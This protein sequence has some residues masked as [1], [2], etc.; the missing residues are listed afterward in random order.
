[1]KN[2]KG[3]TLLEMVLSIIL[4][5]IIAGF[6]GGILFHETGM[7][8]LII[9]RKESKLDAKLVMERLLKEF[10][11]SYQNSYNSGNNVSFKV[12]YTVYKGY[13]SV[14]VFSSSNKLYLSTN[15]TTPKIIADNVSFFNVTSLRWQ[16]SRDQIK[17][18]LQLNKDGSIISQETSV[19]LRNRR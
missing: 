10:R 18:T 3:F 7:F 5:G 15:G 13:T 16:P 8:K 17:I 11:D 9:P 19:Y 6:I 14:R 2:D 12:P 1:M 4:I